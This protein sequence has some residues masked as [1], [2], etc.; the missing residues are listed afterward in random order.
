M[1]IL[2]SI[3]SIKANGEPITWVMFRWRIRKYC[4]WI[5]QNILVENSENWEEEV[6]FAIPSSDDPKMVID[7]IKSIIPSVTIELSL[8]DIPNPVLSKLKVNDESRY[9]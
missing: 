1:L 6:R 9:S 5:N 3:Y 8:W 7:Y 2:R 4:I